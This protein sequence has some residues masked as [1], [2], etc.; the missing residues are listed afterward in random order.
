MKCVAEICSFYLV[1][2]VLLYEYTSFYL[3][4][5]YG[6]LNYFQ[7]WTFMTSSAVSIL[8]DAFGTHIAFLLDI[9]LG[10]K[11]LGHRLCIYSASRYCLT[12]FFLIYFF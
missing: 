3:F 8:T 11:L 1:Y 5:A 9:C 10:V 6:H 4:F 2:S 12:V 7:F